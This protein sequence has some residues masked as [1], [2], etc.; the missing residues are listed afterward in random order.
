MT[1]PN[2]GMTATAADRFRG[3][4][5]MLVLAIVA[6]PVAVT[7]WIAWAVKVSG[8][9]ID[10]SVFLCAKRPEFKGEDTGSIT[11]ARWEWFPPG[12]RCSAEYGGAAG[13]RR[14]W[15]PSWVDV[16]IPTL[17]L[18][19]VTVWLV[20]AT[21][22]FL[23]A[24]GARSTTARMIS[25]G[26]LIVAAEVIAVLS[27]P[28]SFDYVGLLL[29]VWVPLSLL[30]AAGLLVAARSLLRPARKGEYSLV[31]AADSGLP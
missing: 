25:G 4:W 30:L 27:V 8:W 9:S 13:E 23:R 20:L 15:E 6:A 29:I 31:S 22:R 12:L 14:F 3:A 26:A 10:N 17:L 21:V 18:A 2:P 19:A 28:V 16:A 24:A 1:K 11:E 5:K 7:F